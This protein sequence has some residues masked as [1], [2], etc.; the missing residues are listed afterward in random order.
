MKRILSDMSF[1]WDS[2][3]SKMT[4]TE[5]NEYVADN[6]IDEEKCSTEMSNHKY[7]LENLFGECEVEVER[8]DKKEN[9]CKAKFILT[10]NLNKVDCLAT[11]ALYFNKL[12]LKEAPEKEDRIKEVYQEEIFEEEDPNLDYI[13]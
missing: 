7:Y 6:S 2:E 13:V 1:N 10:T 8:I 5:I 12:I 11:L 4:Y 3:E 9:K